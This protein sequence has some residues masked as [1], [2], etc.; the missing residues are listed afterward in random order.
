MGNRHREWTHGWLAFWVVAGLIAM[1]ICLWRDALS[2]QSDVQE[3][4]ETALARRGLNDSVMVYADGRDITVRGRIN[5]NIDRHDVSQQLRSLLGVRTV[6]DQ[7]IVIASQPTQLTLHVV[8]HTAILQGVLGDKDSI[9]EIVRAVAQIHGVKRIDNRIRVAELSHR[10][11]WINGLVA[12]LPWYAVEAP[13]RL[14]ISDNSLVLEGFVD[15]AKQRDAI[16]KK[17]DAA[18]LGTVSVESAI[19]VLP[20]NDASH[21]AFNMPSGADGIITVFGALD[22]EASV[23][24]VLTQ[25]RRHFGAAVIRNRLQVERVRR[26]NWLDGLDAF[27]GE[28]ST[29]QNAAF[30]IVASGV[31]LLGTVDEAGQRAAIEARARSMAGNLSVFNRIRVEPLSSS[32]IDHDL[33]LNPADDGEPLRRA[34]AKQLTAELG[35]LEF[36]P[37]SATL[38]SRSTTTLDRVLGLMSQYPG[39]HFQKGGHTDSLGSKKYNIELSQRRAKNVTGY[40]VVNG[41]EPQRLK[42]TWFADSKPI[43]ENETVSGRARNRRVEIRILGKSGE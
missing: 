16:E 37:N 33:I 40:F 20:P 8:N 23:D 27:L 43:A 25:V 9:D 14:T 1:A 34:R 4:A 11:R 41:F 7:L 35:S 13:A 22:D 38:D 39:V 2:V 5:A 3:R 21:L 28:L 26:P 30:S 36:V 19:R 31:R 42:T 18:F 15:T 10:S 6:T 32:Q 24:T 17:A 29:A 12:L